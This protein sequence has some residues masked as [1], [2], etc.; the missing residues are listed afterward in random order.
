[1]N[2]GRVGELKTEYL[3]IALVVSLMVSFG[4]LC[5]P[6]CVHD[7]CRISATKKYLPPSRHFSNYEYG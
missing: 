5:L 3:Y 7:V 2:C 1:M 6:V 4:S